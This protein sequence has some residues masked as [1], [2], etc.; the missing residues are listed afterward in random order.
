MFYPL[1][2]NS[3][4]PDGGWHAFFHGPMALKFYLVACLLLLVLSLIPGSKAI[5]NADG[6]GTNGSFIPTR[7]YGVHLRTKIIENKVQFEVQKLDYPCRN[8]VI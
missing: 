5:G 1:G 8:L 7:N 2:K 3:E 4:K 6:T